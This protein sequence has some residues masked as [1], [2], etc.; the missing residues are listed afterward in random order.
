MRAR[1]RL[2]RLAV[3][4]IAASCAAIALAGCQSSPQPTSVYRSE[5]LPGDWFALGSGD[6]RVQALSPSSRAFREDFKARLA[7]ERASPEYRFYGGYSDATLL[8]IARAQEFLNTAFLTSPST[9]NSG[10]NP[11]LHALAETHD[12][13]RRNHAANANSDLRAL[14]DDWNRLWLDDSPSKLSPYPIMPTGG[15][16]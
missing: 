2:P 5:Q 4:A 15:Q 13:S 12:D 6:W 1:P 10:L 11:E 14:R 16:P 8:G 9:I 3:H 7:E